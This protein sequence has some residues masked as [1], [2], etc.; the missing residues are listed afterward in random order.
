MHAVIM[1]RPFIQYILKTYDLNRIWI[2]DEFFRRIAPYKKFYMTYPMISF[3][4]NGF[5][6]AVGRYIYYDIYNNE[7]YKKLHEDY[8]TRT[9]LSATPERRSRVD[10]T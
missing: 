2:I 7:F 10:V 8:S 6:D 3:Q 5:S 1:S 4:R 9:W